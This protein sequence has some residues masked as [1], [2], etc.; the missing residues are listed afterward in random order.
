MHKTVEIKN[1]LTKTRTFSYYINMPDNIDNLLNQILQFSKDRDWEKFHTSK[2]LILAIT[3]ELG[4]LAEHFQ[5]RSDSE[6]LEFLSVPNNKARVEE[7]IADIA[8]Y[9]IRLAQISNIDLIKSINNKIEINS[10]KYPIETSRGNA[11]KY[12]EREK[13]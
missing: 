10:L 11:T 13:Q 2:N 4:E 8:I 9:L 12:S 5:W 3:S 6:I 1:T 7:E